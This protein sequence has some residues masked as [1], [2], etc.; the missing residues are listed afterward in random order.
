MKILVIHNTKSGSADLEAIKKAFAA[1]D[2][3]AQYAPIA[4]S[5]LARTIAASKAAVVVAAG[6]DGTVNA[7]AQHIIGTKKS[8]GIIPAGTLNHFARALDIP[9]DVAAAAK[10]IAKGSP[11][12]VDIGVV[13]DHVFVNNSSIGM[14]PR[15]LRIREEYEK[16]IG[17]WP[18]AVLGL[19]RSIARPRHYFVELHIDG[20][21]RTF[22][23][24]FVFVGNNEYKRSGPEL[25]GRPELD[26]GQLA[27]Y[28][29]KATTPLAI[30]ASLVRTFLVKKRR[31]RGF[32][33]YL[34]DS[35]TIRTRHA[36]TLH[37]ACDGETFPLRTPLHYQ[38]RQS[39]E[40]IAPQ[41]KRRKT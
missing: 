20:V 35:C 30:I 15:S 13:N 7:V 34:T 16:S 19:L 27:V 10:V 25:G 22:R 31:A 1:H 3:D 6:G 12:H 23:T 39:L 28:I 21:M 11:R 5:N 17:K 2:V 36:H 32:A 38:S 4:S 8:L 9:V 14:Y 37:V 41:T 33:I 24:P 40:V 18:A 26:S 29:I